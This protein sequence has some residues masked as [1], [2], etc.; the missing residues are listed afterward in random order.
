MRRA[1]GR[2]LRF[3]REQRIRWQQPRSA[4]IAT[5]WTRTEAAAPA[6]G[7]DGA[8]A[9]DLLRAQCELGPRFP[10]SEAHGRMPEWLMERL[11][12][13]CD[14]VAVQRWDQRVA[15][16]PGAGRVFAMTNV[17]GM[18]RGSDS[19][20]DEPADVLLCAHWDTRPV[21]DQDPDPSRRALPV[22][23]ANDGASG[24]AVLLELARVL[25]ASRPRR[26]VAIGFWDGEDLG[27]YYY[28]ARLFA[29]FAG[30]ADARRWR[31]RR[32][33][34]LDMVGK[35]GL[36]CAT[37]FHSLRAA[38]ALWDEIHASAAAVGAGAHFGGPRIAVNDDHLFLNRA[39]IPTVLLIDYAYPQWHTTQDTPERCSPA[40]LQAVGEVLAHWL[41]R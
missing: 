34:L 18:I 33:I 1:A 20:P 7:F 28:G 37:E 26:S 31:A 5:V 32:G 8:R 3:A 14:E 29:R 17:F 2:A 4:P 36:R 27:E 39:G 10:G 21:A 25:G 6:D 15:R 9:F 22:P 23:G 19:A 11:R 24:V 30:R 16:G 38:P 41:A 35:D 40:S 13:G 12:A